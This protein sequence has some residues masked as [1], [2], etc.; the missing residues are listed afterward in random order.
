MGDLKKVQVLVAWESTKNGERVYVMQEVN[1]I[2]KAIKIANNL[3]DR[4]IKKHNLDP[5]NP[6][7]EGEGIVFYH[8]YAM[9][10]ESPFYIE[11]FL[12]EHF[13]SDWEERE[14]HEIDRDLEPLN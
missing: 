6:R 12:S 13:L 7:K 11:Y 3:K 5:D 14:W 9:V 4:Y 1:S 2:E 8:T 10:D